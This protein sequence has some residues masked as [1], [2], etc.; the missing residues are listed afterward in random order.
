MASRLEY[1]SLFRMMAYCQIH[2]KSGAKNCDS[3]C[4]VVLSLL[5]VPKES[6]LN[7]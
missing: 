7:L 5:L 4:T 2:I 6:H 1:L 3:L